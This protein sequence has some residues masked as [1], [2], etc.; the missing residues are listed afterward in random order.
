MELMDAI[1]IRLK[2]ILE[3]KRWSYKELAGRIYSMTI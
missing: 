2:V 1:A 3:G